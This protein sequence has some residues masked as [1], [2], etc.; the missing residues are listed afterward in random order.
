MGNCSKRRRRSLPYFA[1]FFFDE[2][3][4]RA[5]PMRRNRSGKNPSKLVQVWGTAQ[6]FNWLKG[7]A[8]KQ[9]DTTP[10]GVL[11]QFFKRYLERDTNEKNDKKHRIGCRVDYVTWSRL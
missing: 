11:Q 7:I 1:V 4:K 2:F 9:E 5:K 3:R 8:K 6:T 10:S